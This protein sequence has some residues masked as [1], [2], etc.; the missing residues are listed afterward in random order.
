SPHASAYESTKLWYFDWDTTRNLRHADPEVRRMLIDAFVFW[1][2]EFDVDG[3]RIDAAWGPRERHPTFWPELVTA[4][5]RVKPD[6]FL[7]AE[8]SAQDGYYQTH[9]FDAAYDWT[10]ELGKW[11]WE[12]AFVEPARAGKVLGERLRA[13]APTSPDRVLRF[14]NNNDTGERFVSRHGVAL[15]RVAAV[16]QH[17]LPGLALVYTGDEVCAE[18]LPY[19]DPPPISW[20]D[21]CAL[22]AH[23]RTLAELRELPALRDGA[24]VTLDSGADAVLAFG[25]DAGADGKV[26]A[27]LNFADAATVEVPLPAE[28]RGLAGPP[29]RDL[30][31]GRAVDAEPTA[32]GVRLKLEP[33][34]ALLLAPR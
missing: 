20:E 27:V 31:T 7:L 30:L 15:A 19:E 33:R 24:L 4:L 12:A 21:R 8:A 14:V 11:S 1:V 3:Y 28:L 13:G 32:G 34:E 5:R 10:E 2:R 23:Y 18:Y 26:L 25:R 17:A 22:R 16:L 9:G 29:L 6:V